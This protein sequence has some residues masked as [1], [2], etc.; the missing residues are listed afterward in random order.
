MHCQYSDYFARF[1]GPI[2]FIFAI[3]STMLN[4]MQVGLATEQISLNH[5]VV[6][7]SISRWFIVS[8]LVGTVLVLAC[9]ALL[10]DVEGF[11]RMDICG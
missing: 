4:C 3:V 6:L 5:W 2:L 1:Y 7:W 10:W 9:L 8:C 11:R